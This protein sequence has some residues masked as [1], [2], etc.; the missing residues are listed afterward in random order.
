MRG[1]LT[2]EL[3]ARVWLEPRLRELVEIRTALLNGAADNLLRHAREAVELGET[4]HRLAALSAWRRSGLFTTRE[5]AALALA[6]ALA[7]PVDRDALAAARAEAAR[8]FPPQELANVVFACVAANASDRLE[9]G[10]REKRA[11]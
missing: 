11:A 10:I 9:L 8:C 7:R 6:E 2:R 3:E 1:R 4:Q 5:R